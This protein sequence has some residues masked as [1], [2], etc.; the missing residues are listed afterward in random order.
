MEQAGNKADSAIFT[1]FEAI[2]AIPR[3][4]GNME[5]ISAYVLEE[6]LRLG[7]QAFRDAD[8][9]VVILV[10]ATAGYENAP[11][12]M[13]QGH[14]DMVAEKTADSAHDF[15]KDPLELF[16]E[17]G[18]IGA[19]G[20]TLGADDGVAVAY[21]LALAAD[22]EHPHPAL[23][24]VFTTDEETGLIGAGKMDFSFSRAKYLINLDSDVEGEFLT[25]C[26]GGVRTDIT[27]PV[28]RNPVSGH[29]YRI[30]VS[31]TIGGHSGSEIHKDRP[32]TNVVTGQLLLDLKAQCPDMGLVSFSGG[33]MDNAIPARTEAVVVLDEEP[34]WDAE[35]ALFA[36]EYETTDA[37]LTVERQ[38]LGK[39]ETWNAVS[40]ASLDRLLFFLQQAPNGV[41]AYNHRI[42]GLVET[43]LNLGIMK[44]SGM[45]AEITFSIRSSVE[46]RKD[47][48]AKR[49]AD[50]AKSVGGH[51][52]CRGDYPGWAYRVDSALRDLMVR[53]WDRLYG[54]TVCR[55][56]AAAIHAGLE[57]GL[58]LG[59]CPGL[60]I[61]SMGPRTLDIHTPAERLDKASFRRCYVFVLE[62]LKEMAG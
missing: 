11:A 10:P 44:L 39:A 41:Q 22:R 25:S 12:V 51:A 15:M 47:R 26:A 42:E 32:N 28:E 53:T 55:A 57:C 18:W 62:V 60:D 36:A 38:P 50:L 52:S 13:L 16:E 4:S 56:H 21:M 2:S 54:D 35:A 58:I 24:L 31:S 33:L 45:R 20:T 46:S 29:S 19:R 9:N 61:V 17:D 7:H 27:I 48:L 37:V 30:T 59:K 43:S 8:R 49:L 6:G 1:Y 34:D 23:E 14:M 3:G 40:G 5:A